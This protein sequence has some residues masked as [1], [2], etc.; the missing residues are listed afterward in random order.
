MNTQKSNHH[1][2]VLLGSVLD[3]LSPKKGDSYLDL[4]AGYGGH[5][6]RILA[7]TQNPEQS[8]LVDRDINAINALAPFKEAGVGI[9][10]KD[11]LTACEHLVESGKTFDMIL[12]D[13]GI[14]SPHVD[15][16]D[17]GFSLMKDGPLD[18]RMNQTG[19][20]QT[21]AELIDSLKSK[22][23]SRIIKEY[24]EEPKANAIA[25]A[26]IDSRPL[27]TTFDLVEAIKLATG[28]RRGRIHPATKTFQ[29]IRI[30][31]NNELEQIQKVLPLTLELLNPGGR[32]AV[33]SF[34]SLEDRIVKRFIK[35]ELANGFES[36][37][38]AL[39]KKPIDGSKD[40]VLNPRA[41]SAKLRVALKK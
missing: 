37:V 7:L 32:I 31:V 39:T 1:E 25:Q 10:H 30:A 6:S 9:V 34:H 26:I 41:R 8:V 15:N 14:S 12:L 28:P 27:K 19:D 38:E 5:A 35:N 20:E 40:D 33:I 13:L 36:R 16:P 4:T 17:R 11:F 23:L 29:A 21:A 24:G 22:Q 3:L 2:P 18:M